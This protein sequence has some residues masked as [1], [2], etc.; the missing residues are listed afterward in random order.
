MLPTHRVQQRPT[1]LV[2]LPRS[3][4]SWIVALLLGTVTL[5]FF[6]QLSLQDRRWSHRHPRPPLSRPP[7]LGPLAD[8][9]QLS[10]K[11]DDSPVFGPSTPQPPQPS[12]WQSRADEVKASFLHA[13]GAYERYSWGKDELLPMSAS[14]IQNFNGWGVSLVDALDTLLLMDL[15]PQFT[16]AMEHVATMNFSQEFH[17]SAPF[18]ETTIRYLGGLLSAYALVA[19]DGLTSGLAW[20]PEVTPLQ[21][22]NLPGFKDT[23]FNVRAKQE[24]GRIAGILLS[25]AEHLARSLMPVFN[26]SSGLP[27]YSVNTVSGVISHDYSSLLA[28]IGSCQMEYKYLAHITGRREYFAVVD[29]ITD[30]LERI[31]Q[32]QLQDPKSILGGML[33]THY[34]VPTGEPIDEAVTVGALADSAYEYLLKGYLL[35]G[36][37]ERRLLDMYLASVDTALRNLTYIST[38][39]EL[40]YITNAQGKYPA[41]K[42]EHL[43]CFYPGLLSLGVEL[44]TSS[45]ELPARLK[46]RHQ[47]A[48]EAIAETCWVMYADNPTGLGSEVIYFDRPLLPQTPPVPPVQK[49]VGEGAPAPA[50][51]RPNTPKYTPV[52]DGYNRWWNAIDEWEGQGRPNTKAPGVHHAQRKLVVTNGGKGSWEVYSDIPSGNETPLETGESEHEDLTEDWRRP[53]AQKRPAHQ[54]THLRDYQV[55]DSRWLMRP[56]TI[57][58]F[59]LLF[60]AT[61]DPIWRDRCYSVFEAI[62]KHSRSR[63]GYASVLNVDFEPA[64][65]REHTAKRDPGRSGVYPH[66]SKEDSMPSYALAETFKYLYLCMLEPEESARLLPSDR[67]I[68]NTEAHPL[69]VFEWTDKER[70]EWVGGS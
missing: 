24:R 68:F 46:E 13:W 15:R 66:P 27:V 19:D 47:W 43:S 20:Q 26:T 5:Y 1:K 52:D 42:M 45:S 35:S 59:Y 70:T 23:A 38:N 28:E 29:N 57:E 51:P 50:N 36:R 49:A 11:H 6:Y 60:R 31:Q 64:S 16:R 41:Y 63:I 61:G 18:F 9:L 8:D 65:S 12:L 58:S 48:A 62:E 25:R 21:S 14:Y 37:S 4:L 53:T 33:P 30:T 40:V 17:R 2:S 22:S 67:W 44:L 54:K 69:P 55:Y 56:E 34:S 7:P 3:R 32:K 39:R 10:D